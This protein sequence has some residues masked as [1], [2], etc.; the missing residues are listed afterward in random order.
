MPQVTAL[1]QSAPRTLWRVDA[2]TQPL[3]AELA[4]LGP[5]WAEA[6]VARVIGI[7]LLSF[8]KAVASASL[9]TSSA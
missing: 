6:D 1:R 3:P 2:A 5:T 9:S 4:A 8:G 7:M